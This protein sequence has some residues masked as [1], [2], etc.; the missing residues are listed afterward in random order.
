MIQLLFSMF[1]LGLQNSGHLLTLPF[2][3]DVRADPLL[4]ELEAPLVLG[5]TQQLHSA[6]LIGSKSGDFPHQVADKLVVIRLLALGSRGL[7]LLFVRSGLVAFVETN[8]DL[9]LGCHSLKNQKQCYL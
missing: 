7:L 9:V 8:A 2:S 5:D 1:T 3:P 4:Q 6:L